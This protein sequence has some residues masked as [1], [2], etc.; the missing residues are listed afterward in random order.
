MLTV[1]QANY[2][3]VAFGDR[4]IDFMGTIHMFTLYIS[5]FQPQST[6]LHF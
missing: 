3:V 2:V 4:G 6:V 5:V 1:V